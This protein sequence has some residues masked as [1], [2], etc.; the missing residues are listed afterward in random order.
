MEEIPKGH[1][2]TLTYAPGH[3]TDVEVNGIHKGVLVGKPTTDAVL[4]TWIG[5]NPDAGEDFK[6]AVLGTP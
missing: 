2:M 4:S 6:R 1:E 5:D 3:G